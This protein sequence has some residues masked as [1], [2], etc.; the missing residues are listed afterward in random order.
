MKTKVGTVLD[1]ELLQQLK[2][3]AAKENRSMSDLINEALL[4]YLQNSK[5]EREL[6]VAAAK[7]LCSKPFQISPQEIKEIMEEDYFEQ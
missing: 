7:R 2:E 1:K 4:I 5:M 6:R 3:R